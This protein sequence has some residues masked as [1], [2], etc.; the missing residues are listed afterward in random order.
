MLNIMNF[1]VISE[2][3]S[4]FLAHA[5]LTKTPLFVIKASHTATYLIDNDIVVSV[6]VKYC[7]YCFLLKKE[8]LTLKNKLI[9]LYCLE[10]TTKIP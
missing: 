7:R 10:T 9:F 6:V 2:H 8:V 3:F 1:V 4:S 5:F